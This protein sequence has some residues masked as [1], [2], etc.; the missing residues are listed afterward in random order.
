MNSII[1]TRFT[2]QMLIAPELMDKFWERFKLDHGEG[3]TAKMLWED[4]KD[5]PIRVEVFD[6]KDEGDSVENE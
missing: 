4:F 6:G 5:I 2:V 3:K 1:E